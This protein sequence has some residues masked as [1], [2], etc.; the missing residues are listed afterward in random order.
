MSKLAI[1]ID[2]GTTYSCVGVWREGKVEIL[3]NDQGNRTTPSYVAFTDEER[4]IGDAAKTQANRNPTNTVFDTKRLIGRQYSDASVQSDMKHW[5]F[6]VKKS[7]NDKPVIEVEHKGEMKTFTPEEISSMIL[8]KMKETAESFLGEKV[9]DAVI[10][11]PAYFNDAQRR[12]TKDAGA[13]AG[14][15]ILRIINEPTAAALAYGLDKEGDR[16]VL[17]FDLGGGTF[18]VSLLN[19]ADGFFEVKATAGDT[20]LGGSDFDQHLVEWCLKEFRR[21]NKSVDMTDMMK[22]NRVL[23]RLRTACEKAKRSLSSSATAMIE[24][25]SLYQGIDFNI[26]ITR[27]KFEMLCNADFQK[28]MAPLDQVLRDANMSKSEIHDVVLIGGSTRIP[29]IHKLLTDYFHKEPKRNINPDEAVAYGATVQAAILVGIEHNSLNDMVIVDATPLSLGLET[30]GGVMTTLIGRGSSIPCCKEQTFS[31][32]SD[33]QP[34]VSVKVYE[35][36]RAETR[37]NNLLGTFEL[38]GIPP[39]PR[40]VPKINVKFEIDTNG[41]LQ[42]AASEE[43]TGKS[44]KIVIE[45]DK[46]RFSEKELEDMLAEAARMAAED[47]QFK[48]RMEAKVEFENFLYNLR[49]SIDGEQMKTKLGEENYKILSDL[50]DENINWLDENENLEKE[51]YQTK[52]KGVEEI[53]RPIFMKAHSQSGE[54]GGQEATSTAPEVEEPDLD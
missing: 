45:N 22:N 54:E 42:V 34:G 48:E 46:N 51:D 7:D 27:A 19:I 53:S 47:T 50:V 29:K 1:G 24:V 10:T 23:R 38:T 33:N 32:Y 30:V 43:S 9:T 14:L 15:N 52:Q 17:V 16:N 41:I 3:A 44:E 20:H 6:G 21:K 8:T 4:L 39:M 31:T 36:E 18:D 25:E 26:K 37:N 35:G 11:V 49:N 5:S 28:C 13:I 40:G 2:L 12:A